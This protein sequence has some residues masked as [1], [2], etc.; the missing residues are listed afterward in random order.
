[1]LRQ[2]EQVV[3]KLDDSAKSNAFPHSSPSSIVSEDFSSVVLVLVIHQPYTNRQLNNPFASLFMRWS[4]SHLHKYKTAILFTNRRALH[5]RRN[6][7]SGAW[8][9]LSGRH[10]SS[11][12]PKHAVP[13]IHSLDRRKDG[14][15]YSCSV[16]EV[17]KIVPNWLP[18]S[19]MMHFEQA[20]INALKKWFISLSQWLLLP[21]QTERSSETAINIV[22][23]LIDNSPQL[24]L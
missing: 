1:M 8:D 14:V 23:P 11:G 21:P 4:D 9:L 10:H 24:Y 12:L 17:V 7:Q 15:T 16:D 18:I 3:R 5:S 19:V 6:I 22:S 20:S 13:V 2:N